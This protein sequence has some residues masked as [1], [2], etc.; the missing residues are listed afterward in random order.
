VNIQRDRVRGYSIKK[1]GFGHIV[2]PN[3]DSVKKCILLTN[4]T[5]AL[6]YSNIRQKHNWLITT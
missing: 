4:A 6:T 1:Y 3:P 5:L 2:N